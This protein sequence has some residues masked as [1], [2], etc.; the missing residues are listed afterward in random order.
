[1]NRSRRLDRRTAEHLLDDA[2]ATGR[3]AL[4][5]LLAAAAAPARD[6][7]LA[8]EHAALTA[9]RDARL[10]PIPQLR[11][12]S[13]IKSLLAKLLTAKVAALVA[14]GAV[15]ATGVVAA[16]AT[17]V[18]PSPLHGN[19][20]A[21]SSVSDT[22][23][24]APSDSHLPSTDKSR[25]HDASSASPS[26]S[27][28]GLCHAY[29]S[30][31]GAEHGKALENPAFSFLI[32]TAG[33]REKVDA[34]CTQLLADQPGHPDVA[35]TGTSSADHGRDHDGQSHPSADHPDPA[36]THPTGGP[37]THPGH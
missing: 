14:A 37:T 25:A 31:A 28:V 4:T 9:F 34:Y 16:A 6:G 29:T 35:V 1:M 32:T 17:G 19:S 2:P 13:M 5:D 23:A 10:A 27:P 22:P 8:G 20:P 18:L 26:P 3:H 21:G 30:G 7:E 33:G 12:P 24:S 11:R 36:P 15:T